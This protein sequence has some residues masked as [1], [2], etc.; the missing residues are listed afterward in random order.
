MRVMYLYHASDTKRHAYVL[1]MSDGHTKVHIVDSAG[2]KQWPSLE[3]M[4]AERLEA[5]RQTGRVRDGEGAFDY[6]PSLTCD[7]DVHTSETQVFRALARDFREARA[8][9]HGAQLLTICSSRPL[10]Y[11]DAHM[12]VSAELPVLMV[13]ASRAEDA[14]P[15]LQWQSYAARRMVNCYLR[16]SAWLHRWIELAAHLDVP[17]G[18]LPRDFALFGSD[19]DFARRLQQNDMVLWWTSAPRPDLGGREEDTHAGTDELESLEITNPGAY[20]N[21]CLEV[22]VS[23]LA[24][25]CVL[26]NASVHAMEG[27]GAASM[28]LDSASHS[29]DEYALSLIHI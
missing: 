24:L 14:L 21:V 3:S 5:M 11:Y 26:Q 20:G 4:Y 2:L 19:V 23:D 1:V 12:H 28:A 15:A 25:N 7:V 8:A 13:P 22:Q 27:I 16:T 18:N 6:P 9:R 10:S 17:L 29:L